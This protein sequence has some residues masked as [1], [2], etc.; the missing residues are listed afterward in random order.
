MTECLNKKVLK[1]IGSEMRKK[2]S[3]H[4]DIFMEIYLL[5]GLLKECGPKYFRIPG[6]IQLFS[7]NPFI[8]HLYTECGLG[9][10]VHH[11][12][13]SL[14]WPS[15]LMPLEELSQK[16]QTSRSVC[17]TMQSFFQERMEMHH[18]FLFVKCSPMITQY[19][20][21]HFGSCNLHCICQNTH[22]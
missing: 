8:V 6:Y 17:C 22:K 5:Q 18:L 11:L 19:H 7:M 14:L 12:R 20:Q 9:I 13:S 2:Q 1:A 21:S 15:I 10:L 16:Y 4:S 3:I